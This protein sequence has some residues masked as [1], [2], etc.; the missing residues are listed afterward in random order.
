MRSRKTEAHGVSHMAFPSDNRNGGARR[1]TIRSPPSPRH[2]LGDQHEASRQTTYRRGGSKQLA[3][4]LPPRPYRTACSRPQ[5]RAPAQPRAPPARRPGSRQA[6][7]CPR[8]AARAPRGRPARCPHGCTCGLSGAR[9][10]GQRERV[11]QE[12][13]AGG[14]DAQGAQ[15]GRQLG[16]GSRRWRGAQVGHDECQAGWSAQVT[17]AVVVEQ[18]RRTRSRLAGRR[19][20]F[21][22][23]GPKGGRCTA[24]YTRSQ[25]TLQ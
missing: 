22:H 3:H 10:R 17:V 21:C 13:R 14:D 24:I 18:R 4:Q 11:R 5:P 1:I 19:R 16:M 8:P 2:T 23:F 7:T 25:A 9:V 20:H 15:W 6:S 12:E